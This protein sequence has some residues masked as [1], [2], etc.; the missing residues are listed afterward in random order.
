MEIFKPIFA[1]RVNADITH[2]RHSP[3]CKLTLSY[4]DIT[5]LPNITVDLRAISRLFSTQQYENVLSAEKSIERYK[6]LKVQFYYKNTALRPVYCSQVYNYS[7][8][9]C[10]NNRTIQLC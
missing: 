9:T 1:L 6:F 5:G 4:E 10:A 3:G 2:M 8:K 7:Y